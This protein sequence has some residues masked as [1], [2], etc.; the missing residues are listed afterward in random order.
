MHRERRSGREL[1][2]EGTSLSS[3]NRLFESQKLAVLGT[4]E[5]QQPYLNLVAFCHANDLKTI[6]FATDRATRK[7]ENIS[8]I[9][10]VALLID[11]RSNQV[12]DLTSAMAV[13]AIG[14]AREVSGDGLDGCRS[15][16]LAKHPH[17]RDFI[18]SST[19]AMLEVSI[20]KYYV[21]ERFQNVTVTKP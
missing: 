10:K 8:Q 11:N 18:A 5:P 19:T 16:F 12:S 4:L 14:S 6:F 2:E 9:P 21:V 20:E 15:I 3:I 1:Y 13:T 7:F 17:M